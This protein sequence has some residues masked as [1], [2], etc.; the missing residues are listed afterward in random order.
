MFAAASRTQVRANARTLRREQAPADPAGGAP[1]NLH[2][3][4]IH[5]KS[6]SAA[7]VAPRARNGRLPGVSLDD[8]HTLACPERS[9]SARLA[10]PQ[11]RWSKRQRWAGP[12]HARLAV[13][14]SAEARPDTRWPSASGRRPLARK[15]VRPAP[16][17][18]G[19][20]PL[21]N[22]MDRRITPRGPWRVGPDVRRVAGARR[23][24]GAGDQTNT[25]RS[26]SRR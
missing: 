1:K 4:C 11:T 3:F 23:H 15:H 18:G 20:D 21:R 26:P 10:G 8:R 6:G 5:E 13:E 24:F 22:I 17:G 14:S 9:G 16:A 12:S 25:P 19:Y 2:H 7:P